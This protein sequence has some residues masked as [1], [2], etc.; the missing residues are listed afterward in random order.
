VHA[1]DTE[2]VGLDL[3]TQSPVGHG[4]VICA[5]FYSGPDVDFGSGPLVWID[6]LSDPGTLQA[7]KGVLEDPG[8]RKVWHNYGFDRHVLMNHGINARGFFGDTMHLARLLDTSLK[9]SGGYSLHALSNNR[10][11][12]D[13]AGS[14]AGAARAKMPLM[15]LFGRPKKKKNGEDSKVKVL[16][17][18]DE[19]QT[20]ADAEV[21]RRW[22]EYSTLDAEVTWRLYQSLRRRLSDPRRFRWEPQPVCFSDIQFDRHNA[23]DPANAGL[24]DTELQPPVALELYERVILPFGELLTDLERNGVVIDVSRIERAGVKAAQQREEVIRRF[25]AWAIE[26]TGSRDMGNLNVHSDMQKVQFLFGLP[27]KA[28]PAEESSSAAAAVTAASTKA[29]TAAERASEL[30]EDSSVDAGE[31]G[32][33][34]DLIP[35]LPS[36]SAASPKGKRRRSEEDAAVLG[37]HPL[38]LAAI[39]SPVQPALKRV[40][41]KASPVQSTSFQPKV[42]AQTGGGGGIGYKRDRS[43]SFVP[44]CDSMP[45]SSL[46]RD[47]LE[48]RQS[49]STRVWAQRSFFSS[50]AGGGGNDGIDKS[51]G[52]VG[53]RN[54][55]RSLRGGGYGSGSDLE[56]VPG[57]SWLSSDS[58]SNGSDM[59]AAPDDEADEVAEADGAATALLSWV[60]PGHRPRPPPGPQ[61]ETLFEFECE[62]ADGFVPPGA[63]PGAKP[64]KKRPFSVPSLFLPV[65]E[66]TIKGR[67][68]GSAG[69]V[70]KLIGKPIEQGPAFLKLVADGC[71][72][73]VAK[74]ACERIGDLLE[75]SQIDTTIE[76]F[77]EPL[78]AAGL[79]QI[80]DAISRKVSTMPVLEPTGAASSEGASGLAAA[81]CE[82]IHSSA[83]GALSAASVA[84]ASTTEEDA[85]PPVVVASSG[86]RELEQAHAAA[87]ESGSVAARLS[88]ASALGLTPEPRIHCSLN[89]NTETGRLSARR[90]NMQNQ[91][92][93]DRD[94]FRIRS[95]FVAP[96]GRKLIVADYGQLELRVLAHLAG[97]AS[98]ISA[99]EAGGDFHS[100]TAMG[101]YPYVRAAVAQGEVLLE[102]DEEKRGKPPKPLLKDAFK[103]ERRKAKVLNFSIAYGKTAFGLA[104]DWEISHQEAERTVELWY[105]D[106]PEVRAW[107][108][109]TK[110][111]ARRTRRVFTILGRHRDLPDINTRMLKAHSERAAINTPIQGSAADIVMCAML[112]VWRSSEVARLGF[113]MLLQVHDEIVLEGPAEN[114]Q[115][116]LDLVVGIMSAPFD[117]PLLVDL[118]VDAKV[119]DAWGDA[120]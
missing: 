87:M 4:Q 100:R 93:L 75:I 8:V 52:A 86:R 108:E 115:R 111:Q 15:E 118:V 20:S 12:I 57:G 49:W 90:P 95:A 42:A 68:S 21:R 71:A 47:F 117:R 3:D 48:L 54:L 1:W 63:K 107:Q 105:G 98:M 102:W 13:D 94:K 82:L 113:R 29:K 84:T 32:D 70:K 78:L 106:R 104:K 33:E 76:T 16:P 99:F 35:T 6:N 51:L 97:C 120:K 103:E 81:E 92:S 85:R 88:L 62:N 119:V 46:F 18:L 59:D 80:D 116:A 56:F 23:L 44:P 25:K 24:R 36:P 22:I 14:C 30:I 91:P 26:F 77:I 74:R 27:K 43:S 61:L 7:F 19:V 110:E 66:K 2:V 69:A 11:L 37:S 58:D 101:M 72:P 10:E 112:K 41:R 17:P 89:L 38:A 9:K 83:G 96:A 53:R 45:S 109:R 114:A 60:S 34:I 5:S 55:K 73:D 39:S 31:E 67:A 79:E 40:P 64:K 65:T 28:A 50:A